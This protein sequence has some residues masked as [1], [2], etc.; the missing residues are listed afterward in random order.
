MK[1]PIFKNSC[2]FHNPSLS[3]DKLQWL[4]ARACEVQLTDD[5]RNALN[6]L[7]FL[8]GVEILL[9]EVPLLIFDVLLL[10]ANKS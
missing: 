2:S 5:E 9:L 10:S 4:L 7:D 8:L 6:P 1:W 3:H